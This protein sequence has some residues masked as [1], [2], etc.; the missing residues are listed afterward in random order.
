MV[1]GSNDP[2][3]QRVVNAIN[4][5]LGNYGKTINTDR[6]SQRDFKRQVTRDMA[7]FSD[8]KAWITDRIDARPYTALI[9]RTRGMQL[10]EFT[11]GVAKCK[12]TVSFSCS[13]ETCEPLS[14]HLS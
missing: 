3:V 1:A 4:Q 14:I 8:Q 10:E 11:A 13:D 12:L 2:D 7:E 9:R 6:A 5:A